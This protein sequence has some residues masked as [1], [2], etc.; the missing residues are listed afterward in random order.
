MCSINTKTA[1]MKHS[2]Q[3][4]SFIVWVGLVIVALIAVGGIWYAGS[5]GTHTDSQILRIP[6]KS[7]TTTPSVPETEGSVLG[8]ATQVPGKSVTLS[9]VTLPDAVSGYVVVSTKN[10][11]GT[12]GRIIGRSVLHSGGR[13]NNV[14]I[15]LDTTLQ[16]G[17]EVVIDVVADD[18]DGVFN[19]ETDTELVLDDEGDAATASIVIGEEDTSS[20]SEVDNSTSEEPET[21]GPGAVV[22]EPETG[23]PSAVVEEPQT[24][25]EDPVPNEE[26][27]N[28]STGTTTKIDETNNPTEETP[29]NDG[30]DALVTY[31]NTGFS[32]AQVVISRG[33]TV[34]FMNE[35]DL[36]MRV[37]SN[38]HP[39]HTEYPGTDADKCGTDEADI[40]FDECEA[41]PE[42]Y[43]WEY[44]FF[45]VGTW[46]YHNHQNPSDTGTVVVTE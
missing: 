5:I 7:A 13:H 45:E 14:V 26:E 31:T 1:F 24:G 11:D 30:Y 17:D 35:S 19:P 37:A 8:I 25:G 29:D 40:I 46:E 6:G 18:G 3:R 28:S 15:N 9:S 21:G 4:G 34:R 38:D 43:Y 41:V 12:R 36:T 23:G 20:E 44:T 22:E 42:N 32:P 2:I 27:Q 10:S 33:Q 39:T 16:A